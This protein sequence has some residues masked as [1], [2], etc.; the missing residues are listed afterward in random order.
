MLLWINQFFAIKT[1]YYSEKSQWQRLMDSVIEYCID[2]YVRP[3]DMLCSYNYVPND[4]AV[5]FNPENNTITVIRNRIRYDFK[6]DSTT[7]QQDLMTRGMYEMRT[8]ELAPLKQ[9]DSIL[10]V[11]I[12]PYSSDI[13]LCSQKIDSLNNI[14]DKFPTCVEC[15][16]MFPSKTYELG[17]INGE[18]LVVYYNFPVSFF[19][20][21]ARG[22]IMIIG[23]ITILFISFIIVVVY[24]F[25]LTRR[26]SRYQEEMMSKI[27]HNC[28]T[29]LNS[30]RTMVELLQRKS[31]SDSDVKAQE[32]IKFI[33]GEIEHLQDGN[34][35][36]ISML[37]D[38]FHVRLEYSEFDLR[39]ELITLI[40][41]EQ[42]AHLAE[43]ISLNLQYL[44]PDSNIYASRF[45][46]VCAI[47]NLIDNAIKYGK[48]NPCIDIKCYLSNEELVI[49]VIDDGPGIAK[50]KQKNIFEKY[51]RSVDDVNK[52]N[53]KGY[54]LGL[55][56][57][58]NVIR[59]HGG[60][61]SVNSELG[62]GCIFV[63]RLK[64]W[65]IE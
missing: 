62:R 10:Y 20:Q 50:E 18:S 31:I 12:S 13:K 17:F 59:L 56:Y 43:S 63:I 6:V 64:K 16:S 29:P 26:L 65:R 7:M 11:N 38:S 24:L 45:H 21:K 30:I 3:Y 22:N 19:L 2:L 28:K 25:R 60:K 53:I 48:A 32:K 35:Q 44:L 52:K 5:S 1:L 47:R 37:I 42:A 34:Q 27:I 39:N 9:L 57:V 8:S 55:N 41:E 61:I 51:Y 40:K 46:L 54:G 33:F 15:S 14:I 23:V 36:I 49:E 58:Y 4:N